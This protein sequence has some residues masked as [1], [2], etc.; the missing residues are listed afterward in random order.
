VAEDAAIIQH[1]TGVGNWTL[2]LF[3]CKQNRTKGNVTLV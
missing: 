1:V 3:A 2:V